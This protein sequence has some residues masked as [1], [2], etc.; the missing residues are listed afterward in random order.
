[1]L[2]V[3]T[4]VLGIGKLLVEGGKR[5]KL[6]PPDDSRRYI[7][8]TSTRTELI[9]S[10]KS[11]ARLVRIIFWV[12]TIGGVA[13]L[14]YITYRNVSNAWKATRTRRLLD[15]Y[16]LQRRAAAGSDD[17]TNHDG[18]VACVVC[19]SQPRDVLLLECGHICVCSECALALPS[20]RSCPICRQRVERIVPAY[21]S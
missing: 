13:S 5:I 9:R 12:L 15:K 2:E 18:R 7:L 17:V 14:A 20:P 8:T 3:G 11:D 4:P 19:L 1:M 10:L 16:R 21:V 6:S